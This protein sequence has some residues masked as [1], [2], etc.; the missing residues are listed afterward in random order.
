MKIARVCQL[1]AGEAHW[2]DPLGR[3]HPD[4]GV[5]SVAQVLLS[6]LK[7]H[8]GSWLPE[9][10]CIGAPSTRWSRG[11]H[12]RPPGS[13]RGPSGRHAGT[14][15]LAA[16]LSRGALPKLEML[17]LGGNKIDDQGLIALAAPLRKR[18][19]LTTLDIGV[20]QI[21]DEGVAAL[22][23]PGEGVLPKLELLDLEGNKLT[24][25]GCASLAAALQLSLIHI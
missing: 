12:C 14:T 8:P 9:A 7:G 19:H 21:G 1:P 11:R 6:D 15:A 16:A 3:R 13:S 24:D 20:N 25:K 4:A 23:A 2:P 5:N 18:P 22:V 10:A 17:F